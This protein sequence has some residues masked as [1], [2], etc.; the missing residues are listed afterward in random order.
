MTVKIKDE[1]KEKGRIVFTNRGVSMMPLLRQNKDLMIIEAPTEPYKRL[2]A[3][4]FERPNGQLILHR[5]LK[6]YDDRYWIIGDNCRDGEDVPKEA[7]LGILTGVKRGKKT[8]STDD[9]AYKMY[10][11]LWCAPYH[12]RIMIQV[13]YKFARK[14]VGKVLRT[15]KKLWKNSK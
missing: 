12:L 9:F 8:I 7:V 11:R 2:D 5:I 13:P 10:V 6:V 1:L 3:V 4:L 15:V 14:C